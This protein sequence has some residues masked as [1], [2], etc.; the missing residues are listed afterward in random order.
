MGEI[1]ID[2]I[3][4]NIIS[5]ISKNILYVL[6]QTSFIKTSVILNDLKEIIKDE[7]ERGVN[8][9]DNKIWRMFHFEWCP[10][11]STVVNIKTSGMVPRGH[12]FNGDKIICPCCKKKGVFIVPKEKEKVNFIDWKEKW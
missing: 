12:G 6:K 5:L 2:E 1:M 9:P 3:A 4:E 10:Q 8:H 7:I 11:C